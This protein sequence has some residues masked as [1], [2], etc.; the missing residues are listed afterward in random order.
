[1][2]IPLFF[3]CVSVAV[4]MAK[5]NWHKDISPE[6]V[7]K[8]KDVPTTFQLPNL[9]DSPIEYE[10]VGEPFEIDTPDSDYNKTS[11]K[12]SVKTNGVIGEIFLPKSLRQ[13]I[14]VAFEKLELDY[15]KAKWSGMIISVWLEAGEK[16][17]KYYHC[18]MKPTE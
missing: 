7:E 3:I 9:N 18:T 12:V 6:S 5:T 2:I 15:T 8:C 13:N 16:G 10:F 4:V 17:F 11:F 14:A 1:M